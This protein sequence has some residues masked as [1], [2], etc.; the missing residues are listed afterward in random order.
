MLLLKR[1]LKTFFFIILA[2]GVSLIFLTHR[3]YKIDNRAFSALPDF[4]TPVPTIFISGP[5]Q[6]TSMDSPDGAKTLT[7]EKQQIKNS[8]KYSFFTSVKP[9][10]TRLTIF[11][12]EETSSQSLSIPYNAW[13]PDN[14][15][16]FLKE[17]TSIVNNYY[18]FFASGNNFS[19]DSQHLDI[20]TMFAKKIPGYAILDVTGWAAPNLLIVNA[21][22]IQGEKKVSFWFDVTSQSFTQ[23]GTYFY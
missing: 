9:E 13:S 22:E 18:V 6:V 20:Q 8:V 23:L 21:K 10:K 15:Y 3:S 2:T 5:I 4:L 19:D 16:F 12:K 11:T 17:T 14:V 1:E 7:M